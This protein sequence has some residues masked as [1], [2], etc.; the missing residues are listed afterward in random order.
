MPIR[1]SSGALK[2]IDSRYIS[3]SLTNYLTFDLNFFLKAPN[4]FD[5]EIVLRQLRY[6]GMLETVRIRQAGFNVRLTFDEFI[7]HYRILLPRGLLRYFHCRFFFLMDGVVISF[8]D[9]IQFSNGRSRF[10]APDESEFGALS[11]R[12]SK[13]LFTGIGESQTRLPTAS[14]H[15]SQHRHYPALV[16]HVP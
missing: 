6:T 8:V 7:H 4:Q 2:A 16:P 1:S 10:L 12:P 5:E 13:D 11:N 15:P 14:S 9:L 3:I